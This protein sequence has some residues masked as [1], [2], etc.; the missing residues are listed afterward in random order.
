MVVVFLSLFVLAN[1]LVIYLF[2]KLLRK[3]KG[4]KFILNSLLLLL[5]SWVISESFNQVHIW[6]RNNGVFIELG[7]S[8]IS[9]IYVWIISIIFSV[10]TIFTTY[11]NKK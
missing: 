9:L 3:S 7:H 1:F 8:S 6:F 5:F 4:I 11:K 10:F 2:Y